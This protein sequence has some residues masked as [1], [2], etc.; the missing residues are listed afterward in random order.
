MHSIRLFYTID[1]LILQTFNDTICNLYNV[2]IDTVSYS[3]HSHYAHSVLINLLNRSMQ[4]ALFPLQ[5]YQCL[6]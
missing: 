1:R 6:T 5:K 3:S 4:V 2:S